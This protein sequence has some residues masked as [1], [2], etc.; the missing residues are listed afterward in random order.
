M[1]IAVFHDDCGDPGG[2]NT[3]QQRL[4]VLLR[5]RGH[6]IFLFTYRG[7]QDAVSDPHVT[8]FEPEGRRTV[9]G[10]LSQH[11]L[12]NRS[13]YRAIRGWLNEVQPDILHIHTNYAFM[14][15]VLLGCG[16][17]TPAVQTV[18]DFRMVCPTERGVTPSGRLCG[19]GIS[20]KC[21][22]DRCITRKR[23]AL[24]VLTRQIHHYLHRRAIYRIIAPSR[25]LRDAF[26]RE[27]LPS[28]H[29][30]H[31]V[32]TRRCNY[33]PI[34]SDDNIVLFVGYLHFSK[35]VGLLMHAFQTVLKSVPSAQLVIAGDGPVMGDLRRFHGSLG[36]GDKVTFLGAIPE[37]EV[38]RWYGKS[39]LAVLP[40]IIYENSPLTVYEAMAC[41]RPVVGTR[42]GGIPELVLEGKT[43]LLFDRNERADLA[44]KIVTLLQNRELAEKM[45]RAGRERAESVFTID[46]HLDA[47]MKLYEEARRMRS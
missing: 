24:E 20:W 40:S 47:I 34:P 13:V 36:L 31:F 43:G 45:G 25:A 35:G 4:S 41:G 1:R 5:E 18:H 44:A 17:I 15:S 7:G 28:V 26:D 3:Y 19:G 21:V 6:E 42:I 23:Y 11:L 32:D 14:S 22:S 33:Q 46:R 38:I 29:I 30:P 37:E 10:R 2:A 27:G 8:I 16:R 12:P 39:T 9:G